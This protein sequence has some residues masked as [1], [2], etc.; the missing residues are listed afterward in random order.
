MARCIVILFTIMFVQSSSAATLLI[1]G[2]SLSAAYG[3][4]QETAWPRLLDQKLQREGYRYQIVNA[5]ISGETSAGGLA[6]LPAAL[7]EHKPAIVII[8]LGANDG[9]RGLPIAAMRS[10]LDA[11]IRASQGAG[12][13]VMLIGMRMP[14]NFGP[15]YTT[16]FQEIY[17]TLAKERKTAL[18]PFMMEGFALR[19]DLFQNDNL[20]PTSAAQTLILQNV[21][22]ALKPLLKK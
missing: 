19:E 21:W 14:P 2:D 7:S 20:H 4:P 13:K 3:I 5:S 22:P 6:R 8:E 17:G 16:K 10:N 9:L 1:W 15:I 18:L 11:M 12:A